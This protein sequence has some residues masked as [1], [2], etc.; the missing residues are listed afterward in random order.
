MIN[1]CRPYQTLFLSLFWFS[2]ERGRIVSPTLEAVREQR[3]SLRILSLYL[4]LSIMTVN[5]AIT[6]DCARQSDLPDT[7]IAA[8]SE[9]GADHQLNLWNNAC[10]LCFAE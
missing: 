10:P 3:C 9:S 4:S 2:G 6:A 1:L 8:H 5:R 7:S